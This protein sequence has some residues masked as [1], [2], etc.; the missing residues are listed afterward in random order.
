MACSQMFGN[1]WR[2]AECSATYGVQRGAWEDHHAMRNSMTG[3]QRIEGAPAHGRSCS[4]SSTQEKRWW[5]PTQDEGS[6]TLR[7]SITTTSTTFL[8]FTTPPPLATR[9]TSRQPPPPPHR[10]TAISIRPVA[11]RNLRDKYLSHLIYLL[12]PPTF[13]AVSLS[14]KQEIVPSDTPCLTKQFRSSFWLSG[15]S[16]FSQ[17]Q[18]VVGKFSELSF[19]FSFHL[20]SQHTLL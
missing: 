3:G 8:T 17:A 1:M 16:H 12:F 2:V 5:I 20:H 6:K 15:L 18:Q 13:H 19:P 7:S 11:S 9:H 10:A 4:A 14:A